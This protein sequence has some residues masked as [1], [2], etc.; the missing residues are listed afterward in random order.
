MI[1]LKSSGVHGDYGVLLDEKKFHFQ[2]A[3]K[4]RVRSVLWVDMDTSEMTRWITVSEDVYIL[5]SGQG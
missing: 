2:E 4:L 5:M 3:G 1:P